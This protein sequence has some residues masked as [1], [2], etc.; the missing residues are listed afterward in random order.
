MTHWPH[1]LSTLLLLALVAA[2]ADVP[3]DEASDND[4][5]ALEQGYVGDRNGSSSDDVDASDDGALSTLAARASAPDRAVLA[6]TWKGQETGYWCGPG[7]TRI[8]LSTRLTTLPSQ[9]Q[10]AGELGTTHD[11]TARADLVRV[12]NDHLAPPKAYRSIAMDTVPTQAQRDLL[13]TN[14][15]ERLASGYPVVANVLSGWRPPGYPSGTIGHFVAV[16]GYEQKGERVLIADPAGEG[17]AGHRWENV[18]RTYWI[19]LHDL[20]TWIGGRGYSG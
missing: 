3:P 1:R 13:K 16:V 10:L 20:G 4:V 19:S 2:C 12:L 8:A 9:T 18:P 6:Y 5:A 14:L 11:G 17:S 7:S 15:V